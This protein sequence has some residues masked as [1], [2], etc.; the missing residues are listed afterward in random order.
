VDELLKMPDLDVIE[1][2]L[3]VVGKTI[4]QMIPQFQ[5][6]LETKRL[7]VWGHF[8]EAD[9]QTMHDQLSARGLALQLMDT[10]P[11]VVRRMIR[12]VEEIW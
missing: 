5:R 2:N 8:T 7:Y 10:S 1:M 12:Q 3:D 9:L 4:S 6:I 11:E